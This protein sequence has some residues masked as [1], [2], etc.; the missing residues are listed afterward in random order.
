[1]KIRRIV[2]LAVTLM[3]LVAV[4]TAF[5]TH[6]TD[7][8][9]VKVTLDNNNVDGGTPNPSFDAQNRQSNETTVAISLVNPSIVAVAANDYRMV[10][11]TGDVWIG[12]YVSA[13]GG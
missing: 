5:A 7:G 12:V 6:A 1:M 9:D 2:L 10:T 8:A 13:N 11:V 4:P 3:G